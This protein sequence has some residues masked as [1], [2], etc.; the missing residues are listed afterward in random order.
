M[1]NLRGDRATYGR[2]CLG[3]RVD[4]S[5]GAAMPTFVPVVELPGVPPCGAVE[6]LHDCFDG[7]L[8]EPLPELSHDSSICHGSPGT[9]H[10]KPSRAAMLRAFAC[11]PMFTRGPVRPAVITCTSIALP[12]SWRDVPG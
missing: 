9:V 6:A 7:T 2:S 5:A 4:V 12:V 11:S 1:S 8:H 10:R 3:R